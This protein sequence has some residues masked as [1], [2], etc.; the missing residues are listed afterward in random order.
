M[1]NSPEQ[2][3][4]QKRAI[5]KHC[6]PF[7]INFDN[8]T[9]IFPSSSSGTYYV[10]TVSCTCPGFI[11]RKKPCKHMYRLLDE[12][13][14]YSLKKVF[15][16]SY[17]RLKNQKQISEVLPIATQ[18]SLE[19]KKLYRT[20]CYQCGNDNKDITCYPLPMIR[21]GDTSAAIY[22]LKPK[23]QRGSSIMLTFMIWETKLEN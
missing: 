11:K 13:G 9:G 21:Q 16:N 19:Y 12:L 23:I 14:L 17:E 4:R 8:K 6:T 2:I 1:N 3:R 10:S 20:I 22:L 18:L 5:G 7:S 15:P